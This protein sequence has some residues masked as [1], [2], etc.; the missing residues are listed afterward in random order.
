MSQM[1]GWPVKIQGIWTIVAYPVSSIWKRLF[2]SMHNRKSRVF[3][4]VGARSVLQ[5]LANR[6]LPRELPGPKEALSQ[7]HEI[8]PCHVQDRP[9]RF[10]HVVCTFAHVMTHYKLG[11]RSCLGYS[12]RGWGTWHRCSH[13]HGLMLHI[14]QHIQSRP[15]CSS[16]LLLYS[17]GHCC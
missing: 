10:A 6:S 3:T 12:V 8:A 7:Q 1:S 4:I 11:S 14:V 16:G 13:R 2:T 9:P 5:V 17:L 15:Q